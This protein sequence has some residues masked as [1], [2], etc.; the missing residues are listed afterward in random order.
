MASSGAAP[1][2]GPSAGAKKRA[3]AAKQFLESMWD[4]KS[5]MIREK[6]QRRAPSLPAE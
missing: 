6:N 4:D 2:G 3:E 5:K 1:T